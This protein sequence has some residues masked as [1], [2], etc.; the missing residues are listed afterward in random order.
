[1]ELR[2]LRYFTAV[3]EE[4]HFGRAATRLNIAAPTLSHQIGALETLLGAQLFTR[5]TKSAVALTS[6]G[7]RFL[8]EAYA[9]LKQAAH[10]ELIG[11]RAAR[12]DVGSVAVGYIFSAG[13][14]GLVS[15]LAMEFRKM[16][17]GVSVQ[18]RRAL[19]FEQFKGLTEG[20]LDVG[21]TAAPQR[22][23][24]G[25]NGFVVDRQPFFLAIPAKHPLAARKQITPAMVVDESFVAVS[26]EMEVGFGGGN[27]SAISP[28]GTSLNI[29][30][31]MP[32]IFSVMTLVG[33]GVGL[34]VLSQPLTNVHIPGVVFRKVSGIT[35]KAE[36][37][38]VFRKNESSPVVKAFLKYLRTR[39][40]PDP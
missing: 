30:E 20:S 28:L 37:A 26:L 7:T 16:N 19:T 36:C 8:V 11:R 32:D 4:L 3:A 2:H 40:P 18:L 12:G 17:P 15:S 5:R 21:F 22:Y 24:S 10:A 6:L 34:S 9:T 38:V 14:S 35:R 25:L 29:V 33:A 39:T 13:C 27:I 1:M 31:R 23:P